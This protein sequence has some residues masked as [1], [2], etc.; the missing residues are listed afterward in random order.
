MFICLC[1]EGGAMGIGGLI[2]PKGNGLVS[3][4][5]QERALV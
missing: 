5:K 1:E 3:Y 4:G 2:V